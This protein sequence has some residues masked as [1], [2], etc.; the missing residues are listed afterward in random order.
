MSTLEMVADD[1][2]KGCMMQDG[3]AKATQM[4]IEVGYFEFKSHLKSD[5]ALPCIN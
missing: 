1:V 3:G 2:T 4:V 5:L